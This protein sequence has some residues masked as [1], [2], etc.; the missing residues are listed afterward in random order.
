MTIRV[1]YTGSEKESLQAAMD[2]Y[3]EA[4]L[5]KLEGLDDEQLRRPIGPSGNSLLGLVKHL[6]GAELG[7]FRQTFGLET[8]P[9]PFDMDVDESSDLRI[10]PEET[11]AEVLAFYAR[12]RACAD[13]TIAA[14]ELDH[15]GTAWHGA[16]VTLRWV[17][18]HMITETARHAGHLDIMREELDGATGAHPPRT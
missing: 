11:T 2:R 12:A 14:H 4:V 17:L 8:G 10:E 5:W 1:P 15:L 6:G 9:L 16:E 7:W 3:R 18:I 13:E